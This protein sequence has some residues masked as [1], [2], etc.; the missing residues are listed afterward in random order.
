MSEFLDTFE[1]HHNIRSHTKPDGKVTKD[2]WIEYYA[3]VSSSIDTDE[4]F[5]VMMNNAWKLD[6]AKTVR[7]AVRVGVAGG[8]AN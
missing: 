5:A 2:E 3:N 4:Y 6:E 7:G 1:V 8:K